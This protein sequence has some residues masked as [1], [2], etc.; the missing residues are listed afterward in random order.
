MGPRTHSLRESCTTAPTC[1]AQA[2]RASEFSAARGTAPRIQPTAAQHLYLA[3]ARSG[4]AG[5]FYL[6]GP[7]GLRA[8]SLRACTH[9]CLHACMRACMHACL[10]A[11][12]RACPPACLAACMQASPPGC[13]HGRRAARACIPAWLHPGSCVPARLPA[14]PPACMRACLSAWLRAARLV[15]NKKA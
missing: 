11:C 13:M 4:Y 5:N 14:C 7:V 15:I 8:C 6:V 1:Q 9:A 10:A 2:D 12:A 3:H